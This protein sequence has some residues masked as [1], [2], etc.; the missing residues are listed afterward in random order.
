MR[1]RRERSSAAPHAR[2]P[3]RRLLGFAWRWGLRPVLLL[4]VLFLAISWGSKGYHAVRAAR[5]SEAERLTE[6]LGRLERILLLEHPAPFR[7]GGEDEVRGALERAAAAIERLERG[8]LSEEGVLASFYEAVSSLRDPHSWF[9]GRYTTFGVVRIGF[10]LFGDEVRIVAA[11]DPADLGARV[12]AFDGT[13]VAEALAAVRR[14][15]PHPSESGFRVFAPGILRTPGLLHYLGVASAPDRLRL[16][17]GRLDGTAAEIDLERS[18]P[19]DLQQNP[20]EK[21][22]PDEDHLPAY[23]GDDRDPLWFEVLPERR[24]V[25]I[26]YA[27]ATDASEEPLGDLVRRALAEREAL[28]P[29]PVIVDLRGNPG[30]DPQSHIPLVAALAASPA[31]RGPG[32]LRLLVDRDT[33]SAAVVAAGDL[34]RRAGALLVGEEPGDLAHL[35]TDARPFTLRHS[36]VAIWVPTGLMRTAGGSGGRRSLVP[37]R[38]R[39]PDF[40]EW[41][42]G[43]DPA[44]TAA[45]E[46]WPPE[47]EPSLEP[48]VA[49]EPPALPTGRFAFD[50]QRALVVSREAGG[51]RTE[52]T[53]LGA[54]R[55]AG[56]DAGFWAG[57]IQ[58]GLRG[59]ADGSLWRRLPDDRWVPLPRLE[60]EAPLELAHLGRMD[61]AVAAYDA[62]TD[63]GRDRSTVASLGLPAEATYRY[64]EGDSEQGRVLFELARRLSPADALI[65]LQHSL[66][67]QEAEERWV[68]PVDEVFRAAAACARRYREAELLNDWRL[69]L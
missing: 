6:D 7:N 40:E 56:D 19:E 63:G 58:L 23:R 13:P 61:E 5:M 52:V 27:A 55:L 44:L 9:G 12:V 34:E 65:P 21:L 37:V 49:T 3:L 68:P 60:A 22:E 45:L 16:T 17:V 15:T 35:T 53:G 67:R 1:V 18:R 29:V 62:L 48:A 38:P 30:G 59:D 57:G 42:A 50:R 39:E 26:R 28:G 51:Y 66:L 24:A 32:N 46:P 8:E 2:G 31:T 11:D 41:Q 64:F 25:Y 69:C 20:P 43:R 33:F 47:G 36:Q 54:D 10:R 14:L 4:V